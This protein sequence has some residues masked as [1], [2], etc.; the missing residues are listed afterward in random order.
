MCFKNVHVLFLFFQGSHPPT[1]QRMLD[2]ITQSSSSPQGHH[3]PLDLLPEDTM[4]VV[5]SLLCHYVVHSLIILIL[6]LAFRRSFATSSPTS[7]DFFYKIQSK[8]STF[9]CILWLD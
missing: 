1:R 4:M 3:T 7:V 9:F 8:M 6:S 2:R 5:M